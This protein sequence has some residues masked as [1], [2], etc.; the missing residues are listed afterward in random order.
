MTCSALVY[1][2][3]AGL[4]SGLNMVLFNDFALYRRRLSLIDLLIPHVDDVLSHSAPA[5]PLSDSRD[6][7]NSWQV[8]IPLLTGDSIL[9][10]PD[11]LVL[12][13]PIA[14]HRPTGSHPA[15]EPTLRCLGEYHLLYH[16]L[17]R[18]VHGLSRVFPYSCITHRHH[19][20]IRDP[21]DPSARPS[22][23]DPVSSSSSSPIVSAAPVMSLA[24]LPW[25]LR[26]L[27]ASFLSS[28][29]NRRAVSFIFA[30]AF[31]GMTFVTD[32]ADLYRS[33]PWVSWL[34]PPGTYQPGNLLASAQ[35]PGWEYDD[36]WVP[37]FMYQLAS[38]KDGPD[39]LW[40]QSLVPACLSIDAS[41]SVPESS[42]GV[43]T[44]SR[45]AYFLACLQQRIL[46]FATNG[47]Q[48]LGVFH[49]HTCGTDD[50]D[51]RC[52]VEVCLYGRV[53]SFKCIQGLPEPSIL[54]SSLDQLLQLDV[55]C[56]KARLFRCEHFV[57]ERSHPLSYHL[58][59]RQREV[60]AQF[61]DQCA[62]EKTSQRPCPSGRR[63]LNQ[64][65]GRTLSQSS[66]PLRP[67]HSWRSCCRSL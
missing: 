51:T 65:R 4:E 7:L 3:C 55:D 29:D 59:N 56:F 19:G 41:L 2:R 28:G 50:G 37:E 10:H 12:P 66:W 40:L 62:R 21:C 67:R 32:A 31:N 35:F 54:C 43:P 52:E 36:D 11:D 38:G 15:G 64:L 17:Q 22:P 61:R 44:S 13:F 30:T 57:Q 5:S 26:Q 46:F 63:Q 9:A 1:R 23:L 48:L 53:I 16:R 20:F 18:A 8:P 58:T 49:T 42:L 24:H 39:T 45:V 34:T 60:M 33:I 25:V 14:M 27:L 47:L 6:H